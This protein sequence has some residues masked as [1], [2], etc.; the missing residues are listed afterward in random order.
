MYYGVISCLSMTLYTRY[1]SVRDRSDRERNTQWSW[2]EVQRPLTPLK[3]VAKL[4]RATVILIVKLC[5]CTSD[6]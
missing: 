6:R 5:P 4:A 1:Y 3:C 2:C